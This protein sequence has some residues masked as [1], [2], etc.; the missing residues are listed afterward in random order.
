MLL[1][2]GAEKGDRQG[3]VDPSRMTSAAGQGRDEA[4]DTAY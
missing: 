1:E 3:G 2:E 4:E